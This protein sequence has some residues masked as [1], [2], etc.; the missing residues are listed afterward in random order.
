MAAG[1]EAIA[2]AVRALPGPFDSPDVRGP[3]DS[4][5]LPACVTLIQ[6]PRRQL[7]EALDR[8]ERT[9]LSPPLLVIVGQTGAGKSFLLHDLVERG[10]AGVR[11]RIYVP[12]AP[13]RLLRATPG[14]AGAVAAEL[15]GAAREALF[16][17][18][19]PGF[20]PGAR[21]IARYARAVG[22]YAID[23]LEEH[24]RAPRYPGPL[25]IPRRIPH[26][27][28]RE[29]R[30]ADA[31]VPL[32]RVPH[33]RLRDV[34]GSLAAQA[35]EL[36]GKIGGLRSSGL[37]GQILRGAFGLVP[38]SRV[39]DDSPAGAL[40]R[41]EDA[42]ELTTTLKL[43]LTFV[44]DQFEDL[45]VG[46][47][48]AI[49]S[50]VR[51]FFLVLLDLLRTIER[52]DVPARAPLCVIAVVQ[53]LDP[54]DRLEQHVRDRIPI[55]P[56]GRR[57][58]SL[59]EGATRLVDPDVAVELARHY[60]DRFWAQE[61]V[62]AAL[63]DAGER[64][65]P[66]SWPF[67]EEGL[68]ALHGR[69]AGSGDRPGA[70][71][72]PRDWLLACREAWLALVER[73]G[74][75]PLDV[76]RDRWIGRTEPPT[77]TP[78]PPAPTV[79]KV[80]SAP[81]PVPLPPGPSP[82]PAADPLRAP[83]LVLAV[84][85]YLGEIAGS[86]TELLEHVASFLSDLSQWNPRL[87]LKAPLRLDDGAMFV[88]WRHGKSTLVTLTT[89]S[90]QGSGCAT[91]WRQFQDRFKRRRAEGYDRYLFLRTRQQEFPSAIPSKVASVPVVATKLL[92]AH[93]TLLV[94]ARYHAGTLPLD[95]PG[96]PPPLG[97]EA[98][99]PWL[100]RALDEHLGFLLAV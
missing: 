64:L 8:H 81:V 66:W 48:A 14:G 40:E 50:T 10:H 84:E 41:L 6:E 11:G 33:P 90:N 32:H 29:I 24:G 45:Q 74:P 12:V 21:P 7:D 100:E 63:R 78:A 71:R 83:S 4:R 73:P 67:G 57:S 87:D 25:G 1:D 76:R 85:R 36:F 2:A 51:D 15:L 47:T 54:T 18:R 52:K 44:F 34:V 56:S 93:W 27:I 42:V 92:S 60:L 17:E 39:I 94:G 97:A 53:D 58:V 3:Y 30:G 79:S 16:D 43:P 95:D 75:E 91:A 46:T 23:Q 22:S 88:Y 19:V 61:R 9:P 13:A 31:L 5:R 98:L 38:P 96:L 65:P 86:E 26:E 55:L 80:S 20:V 99:A 69:F 77:P 89:R 28:V 35:D 62:V 70:Y 49:L 82:A 37:P 72:T 59:D 68:R